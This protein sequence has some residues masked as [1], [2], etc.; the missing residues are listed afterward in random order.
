[1]KSM[2]VLAMGLSIWSGAG[3]TED[4]TVVEV[5]ASGSFDDAK[6]QPVLAIENH[7]L[8]VNH[9]SKVGE[10]WEGA[11]RR[12]RRRSGRPAPARHRAGGRSG[13][14]GTAQRLGWGVMRR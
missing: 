6:Q 7:G 5:T 11:G 10:I 8:V 14:A 1:M 3:L 13:N 4:E 12:R 2:V 9:E